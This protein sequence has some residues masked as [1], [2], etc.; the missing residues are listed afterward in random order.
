MTI[1]NKEKILEQAN[2]FIETG[3]IDKAIKEYEKILLVDPTDLRVKLKIAEL[4]IKRKQISSALRFYNEVATSYTKEG[5]FLKAV[6]VYKNILRL[7]PS[8]FEIN[9]E[10][11]KL[12]EKM[13]LINDAVRQYD[14]V[15]SAMEARSEM[16]RAL[17]LRKKIVELQ[18]E[19]GNARMRLADVYQCVGEV[20]QALK[21]TEI[22]VKQ[23]E[24][25]GI[26]ERKR[27]ELYEKILSHQDD[28]TDLVRSLINIYY[29]QNERKKALEWLE[30]FQDFVDEDHDLLE[31]Q[32]DL[33]SSLNQLDSAV[34]KYY[35][36][37]DLY[38]DDENIDG[39]LK[40]YLKILLLM[41]DEEDK[42][43]KEVEDLE[44]GLWK[45]LEK[46]W[47]NEKKIIEE[48][49]KKELEEEKKREE[50]ERKKM[51]EDDEES[52]TVRG[53][54]RPKK[55]K[56][57]TQKAVKPPAQEKKVEKSPEKPQVKKTIE[58]KPIPKTP[59]EDFDNY[60]RQGE[61]AFLL[62]KAYM[63]M[64][65]SDEC[66]DELKKAMNL[67]VKLKGK[68]KSFPKLKKYLSEI[69]KIKK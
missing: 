12:Y 61:A 57:E 37:T 45:K 14:I 41:P 19:D 5:F 56:A 42:V 6:T 54:R 40:T 7:N 25:K 9:E 35:L 44:S 22:Y 64:G 63:D 15:A 4:Y 2:T 23:L 46:D 26:E 36:L 69:E 48:K 10:L 53:R 30:K 38:R 58:E 59:S 43:S 31:K 3:K 27:I 65:L 49:N 13:S 51:Q 60:F 68:E 47:H 62:A 29:K 32:A 55:A 1:L 8:M 28:R 34:T 16:A 21:E 24:E 52:Q 20:D 66:N 33:Y 17:E 67:F 50:E 39:V 11:G 18:P